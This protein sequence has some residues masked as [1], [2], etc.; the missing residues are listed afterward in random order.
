[1][2]GCEKM[3]K[4]IRKGL[5][6]IWSLLYFM[7]LFYVVFLARRRPSPT[8]LPANREWKWVPF[9]SKWELYTHGHNVSAIYLDIIGNIIL[10]APLPIFLYLVFKVKN[11]TYLLAAAFL[12]SLGIET[13]QYFTGIGFADIDDI[14]F[15]TLGGLLGIILID[16]LT[17]DS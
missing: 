17:S 7:L 8:L 16:G 6:K 9:R 11:Y 12:L 5:W 2:V 10:F 14:I 3:N 13:I 15:N 1:M 4:N